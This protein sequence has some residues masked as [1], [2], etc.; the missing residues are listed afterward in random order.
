MRINAQVAPLLVGAAGVASAE[1]A[2]ELE[3]DAIAGVWWTPEHDG[4]IEIIID[5]AGVASGRLVAVE[6]AHAADRDKHN[7]YPALRAR[8]LLALAILRGF[9]QEKDGSWSGGTIYDPKDGRTYRATM[10]VNRDGRLLMHRYVGIKLFGRTKI[11]APVE[12]PAPEGAQP[13]EPYLIYA[14]SDRRGGAL[15][16]E[17][18]IRSRIGI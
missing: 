15:A 16:R 7:P 12:G 13:G 10:A 2:A 4:K 1:M 5:A 9:R 3:A 8:P 17:P 11:L 14:A 18:R 6:R